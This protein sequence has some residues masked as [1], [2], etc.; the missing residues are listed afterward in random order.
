MKSIFII[1][2]ILAT[3]PTFAQLCTNLPGTLNEIEACNYHIAK[4]FSPKIHQWVSV[5][6]NSL[7]G[8]GDRILK[9]DYDGD[10]DSMNNWENLPIG[11]DF[12]HPS[13]AYYN[14]LWTEDLWIILY[15]FYYARDWA[16]VGPLCP[17]DEHE[18]DIAKVLV[19]VKR[20]ETGD[21]LPEDLLLG[22]A[23][24]K[25][26]ED[27]I[28]TDKESSDYN[29]YIA[30][31]TNPEGMVQGVHPRI[32]SAT[33]SHHY[34]TTGYGR[35]WA[36]GGTTVISSMNICIPI[37]THWLYYNPGDGVGTAPL[38]I[39]SPDDCFN[40]MQRLHWETLVTCGDPPQKMELFNLLD[41]FSSSG[42]W[43][44]RDNN[45]GN[46][47]TQTAD[48]QQQR[49]PCDNGDGCGN[50]SPWAPWTG[51]MGVN[52]LKYI[53]NHFNNTFCNHDVTGCLYEYN[54]YL[55]D[56]YE[57]LPTEKVQYQGDEFDNPHI[58]SDGNGNLSFVMKFELA[59][60]ETIPFFTGNGNSISWDLEITGDM[61]S[62]VN[63]S[64][65]SSDDNNA[66]FLISGVEPGDFFD[67]EVTINV[68]ATF[69]SPECGTNTVTFEQF[70]G[71]DNLIANTDCG[72]ILIEIAEEFHETGNSYDW[73][74]PG[75]EDL[76][77]I[78]P[79]TK[80]ATFSTLEVKERLESTGQ[81]N[82]LNQEEDLLY[83]VEITNLIAQIE[84]EIGGG[85]KFPQCS[86]G[87]NLVLYPNPSTDIIHLQFSG[88]KIGEEKSF[89]ITIVDHQLNLVRE[90]NCP[91]A[92]GSID[93]S[94]LDSGLYYLYTITKDGQVISKKFCVGKH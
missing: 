7:E 8:S 89:D 21:E 87:L 55:C 35:S 69:N 38:D 91:S 39:V 16:A 64:L 66:I 86:S 85:F 82:I 31:A 23:T 54:P 10:W 80:K 81:T 65:I 19:V 29:A 83:S 52:P 94:D 9:L 32:F 24:G 79:D 41:I 70:A 47:F 3:Y 40:C 30:S 34:Y 22:F 13:T 50:A 11:T 45:S 93:I 73:K 36:D 1:F 88:E 53:H 18:G 48:V 20:A 33:G 62:L 74:F 63:Y 17:K 51:Q 78:S 56:L 5:C 75:Y 71:I 37:A 43:S 77:T 58:L 72:E 90:V 14:V 68:Q 84:S 92:D 49:L 42:L 6:T 60:L 57:V 25:E 76:A 28:S 26:S 61:A 46:T 27:C 67:N 44:K 12:N 2:F 15:S 59:A 4:T